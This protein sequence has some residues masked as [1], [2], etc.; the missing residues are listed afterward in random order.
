[1]K[2]RHGFVAN[3]SSSSF[4]VI[5]SNHREIQDSLLKRIICE[6]SLP[7]Y[8]RILLTQELAFRASGESPYE[9]CRNELLFEVS[10]GWEEYEDGGSSD[11]YIFSKRTEADVPRVN[12]VIEEW[13]L[14]EDGLFYDDV[15]TFVPDE[16][17][18]QYP[19]MVNENT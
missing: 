10:E 14:K 15:L 8:L 18:F 17:Y 1:M 12:A 16:E 11:L 9:Q 4:L 13:L 2:I 5:S 7:D 3:S 6:R 19:E